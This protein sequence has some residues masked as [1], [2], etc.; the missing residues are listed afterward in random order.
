MRAVA[1]ASL[2]VAFCLLAVAAAPA[3]AKPFPKTRK[4]VHETVKEVLVEADEDGAEALARAQALLEDAASMLDGAGGLV[5]TLAAQPTLEVRASFVQPGFQGRDDVLSVTWVGASEGVWTGVHWL[6]SDDGMVRPNLLEVTEEGLLLY[7]FG[8]S[9]S[10]DDKIEGASYHFLGLDGREVVHE[11]PT[12]PLLADVP[13][14]DKVSLAGGDASARGK[15]PEAI[16]LSPWNTMGDAVTMGITLRSG[17]KT[18][19]EFTLSDCDDPSATQTAAGCRL[20]YVLELRP[21]VT[22]VEL[23]HLDEEVGRVVDE[24]HERHDLERGVTFAP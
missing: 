16:L 23:W 14:L 21:D 18:L 4:A 12:I 5:P 1:W 22:H 7:M 9:L 6:L 13:V 20:L 8:G 17:D 3:E 24:T 10:L 19:Q 11:L 15:A 2:G